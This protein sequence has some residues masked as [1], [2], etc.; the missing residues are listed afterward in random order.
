MAALRPAP[1][2]LVDKTIAAQLLH[3]HGDDDDDDDDDQWWL[4]P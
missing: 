2:P 1:P 3:D 4:Q